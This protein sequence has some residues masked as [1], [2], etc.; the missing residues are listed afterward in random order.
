MSIVVAF[1]AGLFSWTFFEYVI[2]YCLGHLPRGRILISRE[3]LH[4]HTDILY[5]TPPAMKIR[6]AV[7]VLFVVAVIGTL[8]AG[9]AHSM[10]FT[11]AVA[12]G[13]TV[14]EI[15]HQWIHVHGPKGS[16]GRW[17]ARYHLYHHFA[18]PK[19]NHGVTTGIWDVI[20]RTHDGPDVVRIPRKQLASVPWL[21]KALQADPAPAFL[22]DYQIA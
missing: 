20:L 22:S 12:V 15:V 2:H 4:H 13:W 9:L 14:Y 18:K 11:G 16:Y 1:V 7:P 5:F 17:A 19:R 8:V 21:E 3:H 6:G 10:A